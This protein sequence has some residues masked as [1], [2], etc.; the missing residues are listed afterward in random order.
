M[1]FSGN[2]ISGD[3]FSFIEIS[4]YLMSFN[5]YCFSTLGFACILYPLSIDY[6]YSTDCLS[7]SIPGVRGILS[8]SSSD[9]SWWNYCFLE[10]FYRFCFY[11]LRLFAEI[12][13]FFEFRR[14]SFYFHS[15]DYSF[16]KLDS[17][18]LIIWD[19]VFL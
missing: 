5:S 6:R 4:I 15:V 12:H 19:Y 8:S 10:F 16:H 3:R 7:F 18:L 13:K 14:G 11:L 2:K 9:S 1:K 17:V